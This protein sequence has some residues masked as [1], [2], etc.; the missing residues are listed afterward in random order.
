M[1][2][3]GQPNVDCDLGRIRARVHEGRECPGE[4]VKEEGRDRYHLI[5][6]RIS[7][8]ESQMAIVDRKAVIRVHESQ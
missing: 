2:V 1:P 3:R 8:N 6:K 4:G 7:S 5:N